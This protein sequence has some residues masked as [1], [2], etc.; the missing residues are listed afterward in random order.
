[1][2]MSR[3][4]EDGFEVNGSGGFHRLSARGVQADWQEQQT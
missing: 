2:L 3:V 4:E 1:M